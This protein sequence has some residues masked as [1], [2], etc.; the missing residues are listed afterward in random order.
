MSGCVSGINT[1][2][3]TNIQKLEKKNCLIRVNF[4]M[5]NER[6]KTNENSSSLGNFK[7]L[8]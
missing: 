2:K 7:I 4:F 8:K 1:S 6:K 5:L 3:Q